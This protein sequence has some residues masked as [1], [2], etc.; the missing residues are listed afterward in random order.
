MRRRCHDAQGG[1][2]QVAIKVVAERIKFADS[3]LVVGMKPSDS[4]ATTRVIEDYTRMVDYDRKEVFMIPLHCGGSR[5]GSR[6]QHLTNI[7]RVTTNHGGRLQK[8]QIMQQDLGCRCCIEGGP[9]GSY[10]NH[11]MERRLHGG[12]PVGRGDVVS[13]IEQHGHAQGDLMLRQ[14][15]RPEPAIGQRLRVC[16]IDQQQSRV[17]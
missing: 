1:L 16:G 8:Q 3:E 10:L 6:R 7:V 15:L 11:S 12:S 2:G 14:L 17:A 13:G 9:S 5:G 4:A